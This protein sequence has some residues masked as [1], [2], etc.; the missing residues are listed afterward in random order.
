MA[1]F[2]GS[3]GVCVELREKVGSCEASSRIG[4]IQKRRPELI[5]N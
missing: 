1:G 4:A 3:G 2:V 5:Q